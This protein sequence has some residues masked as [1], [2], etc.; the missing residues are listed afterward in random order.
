VAAD[1]SVSWAVVDEDLELHGEACAYLAGLRATGRAFNDCGDPRQQSD[2]R[3]GRALDSTHRPGA[4]LH[5]DSP[6]PSRENKGGGSGEGYVRIV[7]VPSD[8]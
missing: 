5:V 6:L 1:E 2:A 4:W 8:T 7:C 3:D